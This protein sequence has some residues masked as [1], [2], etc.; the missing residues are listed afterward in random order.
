[1]NFG[2]SIAYCF[3]NYANFNGRASRSECWWFFLF[4]FI[5]QFV[6]TVWDAATGDTSGSGVM[7]WIAYAVVFIPSIAVG[8]RRLHDVN[9]SGW[10]QL[11]SF[12]IVGII[13]LIIWDKEYLCFFRMI[14]TPNDLKLHS[15]QTARQQ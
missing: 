10:W 6:G 3:S 8:A 1:M 15:E 4:G 7:F 12:T 9:K 11:I 5:L 14:K 13:P 2:Q